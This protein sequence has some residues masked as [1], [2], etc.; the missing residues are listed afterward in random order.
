MKNGKGGIIYLIHNKINGK[1][2]VGQTTL[3]LRRR[4][5]VHK[6]DARSERY[7]Y[8]I[9][10]A[11]KKYG[12]DNFQILEIDKADARDALDNLEQYYIKKYN[13][14]VPNGYNV[15]PGGNHSEITDATRRKMSEC[16]KRENLSAETLQKYR[17]RMLGNKN[18]LGHKLSEESRKKLRESL[19]KVPQEIR[20]RVGLKNRGQKRS[21]EFRR[22]LHES[23]MG[24]KNGFRKN[25]TASGQL[26]LP[27]LDAL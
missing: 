6:S 26:K 16:R 3:G 8:P 17:E 13:S 4:W 18:L 10:R 7:D 22:K 5:N 20:D 9:C 23:M 11:I 1:P 14:L 19:K 12:E 15:R 24:N 27:H 2:Y 21:Q 25:N